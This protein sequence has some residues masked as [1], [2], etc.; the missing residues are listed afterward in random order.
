MGGQ[1]RGALGTERMKRHVGDLLRP[2]EIQEERLKRVQWSYLFNACRAQHE[3][4]SLGAK[5]QQE[6][7]PLERIAVAPLQ[8]VDHEEKG[9]T[10]SEHGARQC[11]KKAL[12]LHTFVEGGCVRQ[13]R[14]I[15]ADL[16]QQAG[17]LGTPDRIEPVEA[18]L[19]GGGTQPLDDGRVRQMSFGGVAVRACRGVTLPLGPGEE[20][21]GQPCLADAR[22]PRDDQQGGASR[23]SLL[24]RR[25]ELFPFRVA[26]HER[27]RGGRLARRLLRGR[28]R[29][30]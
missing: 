3:E 12:T 17:H 10:G 8:V 22:L 19:D 26:F 18:R 15:D 14:M 28:L 30:I 11:F 21:L 13:I 1:L 20:L 23:G 24:P 6:A 7:K 4:P 16:G 27:R 2:P 25:P 29:G 5:A 9:A